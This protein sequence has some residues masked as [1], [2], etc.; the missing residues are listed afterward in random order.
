METRR[1][2]DPALTGQEDIAAYD[3]NRAGAENQLVAMYETDAQA[4]AARDQLVAAGIAEGSIHLVD[5][6]AGTSTTSSARTS[7]GLENEGLWGSMKRFF[8]PDEDAYA[9]TEG[10]RR[11]HAMLVVRPRP[12][13]QERAIQILEESGPLDFDARMEEWRASGWQSPGIGAATV[14]TTP[15]ATSAATTPTAPVAERRGVDVA[16]GKDEVIPIVEEQVRVGKRVVGGGTVRVRSYVVERPIEEQV[17]LREERIEV[18]RHP[19][20]RATGT[21]PEDAFRERTIEVSATSEEPVISKEARVVEEVGVRKEA[22][23]RTETVRDTV[24]RTEVE[25]EDGRKTGLAGTETA[26]TATTTD[27]LGKT[28]PRR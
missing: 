6:Q 20:D 23:E 18:E 15:T 12:E 24:R 8:M 17:T 27:P 26:R 5:A 3:A 19:V 25:V 11:G 28:T 2:A 21:L 16:S 22:T 14:A 7:S 13:Q 1:T 10:V 4:R 9:Y